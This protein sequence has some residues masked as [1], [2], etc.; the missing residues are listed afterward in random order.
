MDRFLIKKL[1]LSEKLSCTNTS[2]H[3]VDV[4][5]L[6]SPSF[7]THNVEISMGKN[8]DVRSKYKYRQYHESCLSFGSYRLVEKYPYLS[9][10]YL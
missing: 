7:N 8:I 6:P 1:K 9:M 5:E 4:R 10:P 3:S 2:A